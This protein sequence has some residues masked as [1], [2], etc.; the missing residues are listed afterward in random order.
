MSWIEKKKMITYLVFAGGVAVHDDD[1][2]KAHHQRPT[3]LCRV[4]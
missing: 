1:E 4:V 3:H 2:A